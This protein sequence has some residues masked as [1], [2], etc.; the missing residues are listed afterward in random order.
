MHG[1]LHAACDAK[2]KMED[3]GIIKHLHQV[4]MIAMREL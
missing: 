1:T 2:L 3:E 4:G